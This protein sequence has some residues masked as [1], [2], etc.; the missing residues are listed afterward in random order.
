[1]YSVQSVQSTVY[2]LQ[3]TVYVQSTVRVQ[4]STEYRVQC[5]EWYRVQST[6]C[7]EYSVQC[8]TVFRVQCTEY[9]VGYRVQSMEYRVQSTEYSVQSGTEYSQCT[10]VSVCRVQSVQSTV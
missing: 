5:T 8:S 9:S 2:S 1:M 10:E 4:C 7:T 6:E 3:R